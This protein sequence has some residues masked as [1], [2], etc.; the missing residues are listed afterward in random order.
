MPVKRIKSSSGTPFS[1]CVASYVN[2]HFDGNCTRAAEAIGCNYDQL[3]N[4]ANGLRKK[5]NLELASALAAHSGRPID[6]WITGGKA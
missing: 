5:A 6:W 4:A 3:W 1:R 2:E